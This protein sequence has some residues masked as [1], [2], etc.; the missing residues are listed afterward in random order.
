MSKALDQ[1]TIGVALTGSFCTLDEVLDQLERLSKMGATLVPIISPVVAATDTRFGTAQ[2]FRRR[3]MQITEHEPIQT[4]QDAEPIGPKAWFDVLLVAPCTGNTLAKLAHGITDTAVTMACKAHIRNAKP[5]VLS[6]ATND[7]LAANAQNIAQMLV[8]RHVYFVPFGQDDY[9]KKT[10][11][12]VADCSLIP[13]TIMLA[14]EGKQIQPVI[15]S[16]K[17]Q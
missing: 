16:P 10:T 13:D 1:I 17:A 6:I 8:R 3:L 4:I 2:Y 7:A 15:L 12:M 5:L 9:I 11:S 14:L